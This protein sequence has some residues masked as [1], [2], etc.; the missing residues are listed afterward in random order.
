MK[1]G[2]GLYEITRRCLGARHV[3]AGQVCEVYAVCG[4]S[5]VYY[6]LVFVFPPPPLDKVHPDTDLPPFWPTNFQK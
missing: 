3:G 5:E 6:Q 4:V 1:A 2:N